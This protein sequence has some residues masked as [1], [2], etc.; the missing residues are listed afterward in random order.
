M[1]RRAAGQHRRERNVST[2]T[3]RSG[4]P[5][6]RPA[7]EM[8]S[9]RQATNPHKGTAHGATLLPVPGL[10]VVPLDD[11]LTRAEIGRVVGPLLAEARRQFGY[12]APVE[13]T[14]WWDGTDATKLGGI[15]AL[16]LAW[17]SNDPHQAAAE[18]LKAASVDVSTGENWTAVSGR[19]TTPDTLRSR[20][21]QLGPM[22]RA[23][24]PVAARRWAATGD[25]YRD[26][27]R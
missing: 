21:A 22:A 12:V 19:L 11:A 15:L 5:P 2:P 18:A 23:V 17:A 3:Q 9:H 16:A 13:S 20:R 6:Q 25:S 4:A 26:G 10:L 1:A 14:Q 24:D 27:A 7:P 8:I